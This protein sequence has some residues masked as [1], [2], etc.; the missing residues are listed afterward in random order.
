[1]FPK[2]VAL[3]Q[4]AINL[5]FE[6]SRREDCPYYFPCPLPASSSGSCGDD[7]SLMQTLHSQLVLQGR[8]LPFQVNLTDDMQAAADEFLQVHRLPAEVRAK[9]E[10]EMLRAQVTG[11]SKVR[12]RH[13]T[14]S[15]VCR[16]AMRFAP[17]GLP[18]VSR[19]AVPM[20]P[21]SHSHSVIGGAHG[22]QRAHERR[23]GP[24]PLLGQPRLSLSLSLL[25]FAYPNP[26]PNPDSNGSGGVS[27]SQAAVCPGTVIRPA[28]ACL[29]G[30]VIT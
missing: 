13:P 9:V 18:G 3:W 2:E 17:S 4:S 6:E 12:S 27:S 22:V 25:A 26:N 7:M 29:S 11:L 1:M 15:V 24:L 8:V 30:D 28:P 14:R 10:T 23:A 5:Q 16:D 20:Q 21:P 19:G